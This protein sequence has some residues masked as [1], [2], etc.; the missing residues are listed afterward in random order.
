MVSP[1]GH[2]TLHCHMTQ[3]LQLLEIPE[4]ESLKLSQ[5]LPAPVTGSGALC[6]LVLQIFLLFHFLPLLPAPQDSSGPRCWLT[7]LYILGAH[8]G[9]LDILEE[10]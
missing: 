5:Q 4:E 7:S 2:M 1:L 3:L 9:F 8:P 6:E 10:F